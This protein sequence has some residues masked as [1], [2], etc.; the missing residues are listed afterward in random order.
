MTNDAKRKQKKERNS[1][2]QPCSGIE[3]SLAAQIRSMGHWHTPGQVIPPSSHIDTNTTHT[4]TIIDTTVRPVTCQT[5][6]ITVTHHK[7]PFAPAARQGTDSNV[8][9][10]RREVVDIHMSIIMSMTIGFPV[11]ADAV[12]MQILF[13][14]G[15]IFS[16]WLCI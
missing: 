2:T 10:T 7:S 11:N 4:D 5:F 15:G 9:K 13:V 12:V 16:I 8:C 6:I 14:K 3:I 1:P